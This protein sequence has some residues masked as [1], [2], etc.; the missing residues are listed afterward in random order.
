[1][2]AQYHLLVIGDRASDI[3]RTRNFAEDLHYSLKRR[4]WGT[5]SDPDT[6]TTELVVSILHKK[7][8]RDA[9]KLLARLMKEH[10]MESEINVKQVASGPA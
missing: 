5:T 6:M 1:V 2:Y 3:P 10:L 7:H 4:G 9:M 8:H